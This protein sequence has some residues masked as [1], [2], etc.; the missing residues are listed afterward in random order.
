MGREE[1]L[2]W[3]LAEISLVKERSGGRGKERKAQDQTVGE[4]SEDMCP[5]DFSGPFSPL[6]SH[7]NDTISNW[8]QCLNCVKL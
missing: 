5:G 3:S 6:S 4:P 1:Q 8:V 7:P 2:A